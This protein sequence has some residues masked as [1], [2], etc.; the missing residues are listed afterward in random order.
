MRNIFQAGHA[1]NLL[2]FESFACAEK[3]FQSKFY[4][5]VPGLKYGIIRL[6]GGK[7]KIILL[8]GNQLHYLYFKFTNLYIFDTL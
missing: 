5:L 4:M 2:N 1:I 8:S 3:R 7:S 6:P